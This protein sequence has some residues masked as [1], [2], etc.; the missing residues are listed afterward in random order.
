MSYPEGRLYEALYA[1]YIHK[2]HVSELVDFAGSLKGKDILDLCCGTGR[3][4]Q[5]CIKRGAK[6]TG[7]DK[8]YDMRCGIEAWSEGVVR[9]CGETARSYLLYTSGH[10]IEF[11]AVFCRQAV[12][13]WLN[14]DVAYFLS[15]S[16]ISGGKFIFNTFNKKPGKVPVVK[17]YEYQ[18]YTFIETSWLVDKT[19]HHVQVREGLPPHTTEFQW[20]SPEKFQSLLSPYFDIEVKESGPTSIYVCTK[21]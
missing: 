20:I 4:L 21:L 14:E 11:D 2:R 16:I 8:S 15:K 17:K 5:E 3:L 9:T 13:Y 1:K 7:V 12:N 10:K 19:V 6:A 18:G